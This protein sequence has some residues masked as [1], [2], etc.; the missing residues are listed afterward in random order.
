[1]SVLI[2]EVNLEQRNTSMSFEFPE[3]IELR[4]TFAGRKKNVFPENWHKNLGF[5]T[6]GLIEMKVDI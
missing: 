4:I 6:N 3:I 2:S 5:E 1:M